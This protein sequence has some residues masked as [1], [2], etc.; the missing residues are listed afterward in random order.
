MA[1]EKEPE[2]ELEQETATEPA[3]SQTPERDAWLAG[4][5]GKYPDLGDDEEA[6]YKASREG[7]DREHKLNKDNA[8]D[9]GKIY[10]AIQRSPETA[11]FISRLTNPEEGARP[12]EAFAEFGDE[13][14]QLI[15][16]EID[17]PAYREKMAAKESEKAAKDEADKAAGEAY[18][19][20]CE[21]LGLD[22]EKAEQDIIAKYG[23][24]GQWMAS[25]DFFTALLKSLTYDDDM[26]AAELRGRNAQVT[27]RKATRNNNDGLPRSGSAGA[28]GKKY[29]P[30]SLAAMAEQ[31]RRMNS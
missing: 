4:M 6:L 13:L 14:R 28:Q 12:E 24:D 18:V 2:L 9:Y 25:K 10:D 8:E 17:A 26:A 7:Y 27:E 22:P 21:E 29:D 30:N 20:A 23:K 3:V 11:S 1:K 31:R 16:G 19:A 15:A 5:K